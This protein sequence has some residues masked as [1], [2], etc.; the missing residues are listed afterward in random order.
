MGFSDDCSG[1]RPS[2]AALVQ[3]LQDV[4]R[5]GKVFYVSNPGNAGDSLIAAATFQVLRQAGIRWKLLD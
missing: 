3:F 5:D 2:N 4:C 1:D